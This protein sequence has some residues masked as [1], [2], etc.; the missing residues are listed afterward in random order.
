MIGDQEHDH[1][2]LELHEIHDH[3]RA[4]AIQMEVIDPSRLQQEVAVSFY[5]CPVEFVQG[6]A[7]GY[8]VFDVVIL[9]A[10]Y[11]VAQCANLVL[12][13][14]VVVNSLWL[15]LET[16]ARTPRQRLQPEHL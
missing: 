8:A 4:W 13:P 1:A 6:K 11:R 16:L 15:G 7:V 12:K 9:A 10:I 2:L 3:V 5:V 14:T